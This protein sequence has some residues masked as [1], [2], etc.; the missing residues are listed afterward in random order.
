MGKDDLQKDLQDDEKKMEI[1]EMDVSTSARLVDSE[2]STPILLKAKD[3][4]QDELATDEEDLLSD[5]EGS[6]LSEMP[7][8]EVKGHLQN[9]DNELDLGR[10][11][12]PPH[13]EQELLSPYFCSGAYSRHG[14]D[15]G[16]KDAESVLSDCLA[17]RSV[18]PSPCFSID[19]DPHPTGS[20]RMTDCESDSDMSVTSGD[21]KKSGERATRSATPCSRSEA[22]VSNFAASRTSDS[23]DSLYDASRASTGFSRSSSVESRAS[24]KC[25]SPIAE[26]PGMMKGKLFS[27][28]SPLS[29]MDKL[30]TVE[31]PSSFK[32]NLSSIRSPGSIRGNS[33]ESPGSIKVN[34]MDS[35][36]SIKDDSIASP[37]SIKGNSVESPGSI[38]GNSVESL[39]SIKGN[40]MESPDSIK[41]NSMESPGSIKGISMESPGSI[42]GNSVDSPGSIKGNSI[43]SPSSIKGSF[44]ESPGM[45]EGNLEESPGLTKGDSIKSPSSVKG[46]S[47]ESPHS[48]IGKSAVAVSPN[49][50][51]ERSSLIRSPES[52]KGMSVES[53]CSIIGKSYL[54]GSPSNLP[55]KK[56][57]GLEERSRN[58]SI[59]GSQSEN[60]LSNEPGDK[61]LLFGRM[62]VVSL[63]SNTM[64]C[65]F[66]NAER[67]EADANSDGGPCS[68]LHSSPMLQGQS[69]AREVSEHLTGELI[70]TPR[71]TSQ[72]SGASHGSVASQGSTASHCSIA[73]QISL[74]SHDSMA[75]HAYIASHGSIPNHSPQANKSFQIMKRANDMSANSNLGQYESTEHGKQDSIFISRQHF[76]QP[77]PK[78]GP[79]PIPTENTSESNRLTNNSASRTF[80][81]GPILPPSVL[82]EDRSPRSFQLQNGLP[83][84]ATKSGTSAANPYSHGGDTVASQAVNS[85]AHPAHQAM[86]ANSGMLG[87]CSVAVPSPGFMN[88][89]TPSPMTKGI[90]SNFP[91]SKS[92]AMMGNRS[93]GSRPNSSQMATAA[94]G[95][96]SHQQMTKQQMMSNKYNKPSSSNVHLQNLSPCGLYGLPKSS[97][98]TGSAVQQQ[99]MLN[100]SPNMN[101]AAVSN[102]SPSSSECANAAFHSLA[103]H[104]R[105][106]VNA[107]PAPS[108]AGKPYNRHLQHGTSRGFGGG[109]GSGAPSSSPKPSPSALYQLP[110]SQTVAPSPHQIQAPPYMHSATAVQRHI[111]EPF[112]SGSETFSHQQGYISTA[113]YLAKLQQLTSD[114][115]P[116][117]THYA[118]SLPTNMSPSPIDM[119]LPSHASPQRNMTPPNIPSQRLGTKQPVHRGN[120]GGQHKGAPAAA[121]AGFLPDVTIQ[122]S[123]EMI[124]RYQLLS[125]YHVQQPMTCPSF[126]HQGSPSQI[127]MQVGV[128]NVGMHPGQP[129]PNF[130]P[131]V[132]GQPNSAVYAAYGYING[133]LAPQPFNMNLNDLMRR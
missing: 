52:I 71:P 114:L 46:S 50:Q 35:P 39:C 37:G 80:S 103:A 123:S 57:R 105:N 129:T 64:G 36:S 1:E 88:S 96:F 68:S 23:G 128:M 106:L 65:A 13:L 29:M 86:S 73:S 42:K 25:K 45:V 55:A 61:H 107:S 99:G 47:L 98:G 32:E 28:A 22:A 59:I 104:N 62:P 100:S 43:N 6:T 16:S 120:S 132:Q 41:G 95:G 56:N 83:A 26:S 122:P 20:K 94:G 117:Q 54:M 124:A 108:C 12:S 85:R 60:W 101:Y 17:G 14:L 15:L 93:S 91:T 11:P 7:Q 109:G 53:P 8:L 70:M 89:M 126:I 81:G 77:L 118:M 74:T 34:A 66:R 63:A 84:R 133:S 2:A 21:E 18:A 58:T 49:S 51:V 121:A 87:Q 24:V 75:S 113:T 115:N 112:P 40:S 78:L 33:V 10:S 82:T 44:M 9:S 4:E 3:D 131:S 110:P 125:G 30:S 111:N 27:V 102:L 38:K 92:S 69:T 130:M 48:L 79:G 19:G 90:S 67:R 119:T 72:G 116:F 97:P 31:S 5:N 76:H 127:P